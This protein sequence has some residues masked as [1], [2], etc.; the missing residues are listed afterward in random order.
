MASAGTASRLDWLRRV[1]A[2][3]G[4]ALPLRRRGSRR[5]L[6][7]G[8]ETLPFRSHGTRRGESAPSPPA[9]RGSGRAGGLSGARAVPFA[10]GRGAAA[11]M[12]SPWRDCAARGGGCC[13]EG[14]A[15]AA[16]PS[17]RGLGRRWVPGGRRCSTLGA[18][19]CMRGLVP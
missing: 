6:R 9:A 15:G 17:R 2:L 5:R 11:V 10:G 12:V 14:L 7:Q 19:L 3:G 13:S 18:S 4:H 16:F 1:V 8:K